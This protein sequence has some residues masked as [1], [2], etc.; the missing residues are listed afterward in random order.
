M[1]FFSLYW[2]GQRKPGVERGAERRGRHADQ[3]SYAP[4]LNFSIRLNH[5]MVTVITNAIMLH[6]SR[7]VKCFFL[8]IW[9]PTRQRLLRLQSSVI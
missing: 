7:S 3:V 4:R 2:V 6:S 5:A 9:N 1:G 8:E